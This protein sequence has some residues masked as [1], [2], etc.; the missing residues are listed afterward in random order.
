[1]KSFN[2][3]QLKTK[4][5]ARRQRQLHR[6]YLQAVLCVDDG[7]DTCEKKQERNL[8]NLN[9][10]NNLGYTCG[11]ERALS[12][13]F[14]ELERIQFAKKFAPSC[15]ATQAYFLPRPSPGTLFWGQTFALL[16]VQHHVIIPHLCVCVCVCVGGG[17]RCFNVSRKT[18]PFPWMVGNSDDCCVHNCRAIVATF[19][20][21]LDRKHLEA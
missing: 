14:D 9:N 16:K 5:V 20:F 21:C 6:T 7:Y 13:N 2:R 1:M 15:S 4:N 18:H 10:W 19:L 12:K 3:P 17:I 8:M 11:T